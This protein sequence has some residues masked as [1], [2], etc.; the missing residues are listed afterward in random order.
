MIEQTMVIDASIETVY[1][2]V[3]RPEHVARWWPDRA[4][5]QPVAGAVG[6]I[7]FGEHDEAAVVE[8]L[9][10]IEATPPTRFA[11]RWRHPAG[12][13]ATEANSLLVVFD[14][15]RDG[16]RTRLTL[17]ET[18]HERL[19]LPTD[20]GT[21]RDQHVSGWELFLPRLVTYA[22]SVGAAS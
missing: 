8:Q 7:T 9:T 21:L 22:A 19:D 5:F 11:F 14:L 6:H 4:E 10:V 3:S 18:G 12:T 17:T 1:E 13:P 20:G 16:P 15:E 2:V